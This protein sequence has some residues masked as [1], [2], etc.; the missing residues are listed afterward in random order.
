MQSAPPTLS[1]SPFEG[2][3]GLRSAAG[4]WAE[5]CRAA[6]V[7]PL[8]NSLEWIDAHVESWSAPESVF[9][10]VLRD[11]DGQPVA[12]AALRREPRRG[13][14]AL[15]RAVLAQD[16]S[17][18]SDYLDL[19]VRPGL[20]RP[21]VEAL[22]DLLGKS[23]GID[24]CMLACVP[25]ESPTLACLR[26][27]LAARGLPRREVAVECFASDLP[28][29]FEAFL[30]GLKKRMR[31]KV[32]S[33]IRRT[34]ERAAQLT[35]CRDPETL[36]EELEGLY[37][38]HA[39]RWEAAGERGS[40]AERERREF[41]RRLARSALAGGSLRFARLDL[42]GL[43]VAYQF[44]VVAGGAYYQLQEGYDTGYGELRV[45]TALRGLVIEALIDEGL[46]RYDFMAG[47]SRHKTD[48]GGRLRPCVSVAF[49]LP[50][51]RARLAYGVRAWLDR[52]KG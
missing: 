8:C 16:G 30:G 46:R 39:M 38:L 22:L 25:A 33:A 36:D 21:A 48:W 23:R 37:R 24:A 51:L 14:L 20:E 45:G 19:P 34:G 44:G 41:Y 40:F 13:R 6:R 43:P 29:S 27:A 47:G 32:R 9:G 17:F 12:A 26:E 42:D 3:A 11:A 1:A 5:L 18:D 15:R 31:S 35:W 4:P 10:W 2:L 49:A 7:D 50:R 28:E 52:R